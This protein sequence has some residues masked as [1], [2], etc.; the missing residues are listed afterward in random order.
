MVMLRLAKSSTLA[1]VAPWANVALLLLAVVVTALLAYRAHQAAS[2]HR[3]TAEQ[4]LRE[5]AAFAAFEL[6]NAALNAVSNQHRL[7]MGPVLRAASARPDAPLEPQQVADL[8]QP[9][10]PRCRCLRG[11]Q[12]YYRVTFGDS[13]VSTTP[14]PLATAP[15]LRWFRDTLV[16]HAAAA[17]RRFERV[18]LTE[19]GETRLAV[20]T[21]PTPA[22]PMLYI[23]ISA[24]VDGQRVV[25]ASVLI[26]DV[27]GRPATGYGFATAP[28]P[29][30]GDAIRR[31]LQ[32]QR[33][34]PAA[35]TRGIPIDSILA[36]RVQ[37]LNGDLVFENS[38]T[39]DS[40]YAAML[41]SIEARQGG[42]IFNVAINPA[43]ADRFIIGGMP[44]SRLPS[45]IGL[46]ALSAGLLVLVI[47]QLSRQ[48]ELMRLR[49]EFVSG[50]SHE[51][52]TPLAQIRVLAELLRLG[53]IPTEERRERSLRIIDQEARRLTFLVESI[54]NFST[55]DREKVVPTETDVAAEIDEIVTGFEPLASNHS[56]RLETNLERGLVANVD[57]SAMRQMLLNLLDNAVRYGPDGQTVRVTTESSNGTWRL[58]VEDQGRGIPATERERI[59]EPYYR[60]DRDA[61]GE[62][63]GTGIGL[64]VVRGLVEKHGGRVTVGDPGTG[65]GARFSLELPIAGPGPVVSR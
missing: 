61:R 58:I 53:K 22:P 62:R 34:L 25:Y 24:R 10:A 35:L 3:S 4:T 33:L 28:E 29:Y 15:A 37:D 19:T 55:L 39:F 6:K 48:Q 64:A 50:V 11:A 65:S 13:A 57:R 45:L 32:G 47:Y 59:F 44:R 60:L 9:L 49:S 27:L 51:L 14:S 2:A 38:N 7:A 17:S 52:R 31:V 1:R 43:M 63:G 16:T 42:L 40:R 21:T 30:F 5:Y 23:P 26:Y 54:L 46:F 36:V 18:L 41:D 20:A 12:F 56:V 8:T